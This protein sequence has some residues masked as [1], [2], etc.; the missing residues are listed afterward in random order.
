MTRSMADELHSSEKALRRRYTLQYRGALGLI[1]LT[2]LV[3]AFQLNRILTVNQQQAEIASVAGAQRMLSQRV[4]LLLPRVINSPYVYHRNRAL[5]EMRVA[6]EELRRGHSFLT[7]PG[8]DGVAPINSSRELSQHYAPTGR[9]L[10]RMMDSFITAF[11]AFLDDPVDGQGIEFQRMNAEASL[12]ARLDQAVRLHAD[13]SRQRLASAL[14]VHGLSVAAAL[15]LLILEIV[16]VFRPM[17]RD[18]ARSVAQMSVKLDERTALLSRSFKIAGIGHWRATSQNADPVWMSQELLDLFEIDKRE[19]FHPISILQDGD[20]LPENV[21]VVENCQHVAFRKTWDTG[22]PTVARSQF[23]KP[24]GVI[25]D[26]VAHMDA[27]LDDQGRVIGV[28]G[29]VMDVSEEAQAQRELR[30]SY[31]L[32]ASKGQILIEAQRLGKLATW[33]TPLNSDMTQ[34]DE[35]TFELLRYDPQSFVTTLEKV[36]RLYVDDGPERIRA[37]QARV[38]ET[39][40]RASADVKFQCGDGTILDLRVRSTLELDKEG[41]PV[42]FFGTLQD[43]SKEKAAERELEQLAYFDHLTGLANRTMFTRELKSICAAA[44]SGQRQSALLLIDLDHFKEVNDTLGHLAG[45]QLLSIVGQRLSMLISKGDFVARLGGD[46]FA[47]IIKSDTSTQALDKLCAEI[48]ETIGLT[49]NLNQGDVQTRAS[50]GI[51][52]A[53][54]DSTVP[55][56]MLRFAD[57]ALYASKEKGRGRASYYL[58]A[59]SQAMGA[60]LSLASEIRGALERGSFEVHYQPVVDM[61]SGRVSG[62][63]ALLRLPHPERGYIPPSEFIPIAESS[64]LIADLGSFVMHECCREAQSWREAGLPDRQVAVNVSAAQVWHG[65]LEKVVDSALEQSGLDPKLLCIELTESVFA[66][67]S[68][69]RLEGILSR[70]SARGITLALD[71]FGTGYSSLGYLNRLSFDKLKID[72]TFVSGADASPEKQ[73]MLRGVVSLGKGLGLK[74]VAEGVEN[75]AELTLIRRLGC[76]QVQGWLFGKAQLAHQAVVEAASI[77]S[78]AVLGPLARNRHEQAH[79]DA[80]MKALMHGR[81]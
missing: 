16:V 23:R 8:P 40:Q 71:D 11:E 32:L 12:A 22:L 36:R 33:R 31:D 81:A 60:R 7:T 49:A 50:I 59:F 62:F 57:L 28:T 41:R 37:L 51:A 20:I 21:A 56:E 76:D 52:L 47:V 24:N 30:A 9:G 73:K 25:I 45:D 3:G 64:H 10:N 58:P 27:D 55:E 13:V 67:D 29:V 54:S 1:A 5:A 75:D 48:I 66:A 38:L 42:A 61:T 43:I 79:R 72:R 2:V 65:D 69:A 74:V 44:A 46:E 26:M 6:V 77:D 18:A 15:L 14:K 68:I 34:W 17:A 19:G 39:G 78:K 53:P 80:V 63:E 35:R 4:A 70:L